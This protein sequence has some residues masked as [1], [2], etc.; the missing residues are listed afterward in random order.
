MLGSC[1]QAEHSIIDSGRN[2]TLPI[3]W[4]SIW[5]SHWLAIH[6]LSALTLS[7]D[8]LWAGHILIKGMWE[9]GCLYPSTGRPSWLQE[10]TT[11]GSISPLLGVLARVTS[12]EILRP[13]TNTPH[14]VSSM[15]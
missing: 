12:R 11:S 15:F 9:D 5:G 10:V 13:P 3:G 14:S 2:W 8:I 7:L 1:L 4:V 6:F